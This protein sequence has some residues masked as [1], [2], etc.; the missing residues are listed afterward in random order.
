MRDFKN[1]KW[2][3]FRKKVF[4]RY[5]RKCMKCGT[6]KGPI[7]VDHI[8]AYCKRPD[9]EYDINNTQILCRRCNKQKGWRSSKDYRPLLMRF[10]YWLALT[11]SPAALVFAFLL[12][13]PLLLAAI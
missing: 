13:L 6:T 9:L 2:L 12:F 4:A 1:P 8:I 5:G 3:A 11:A 7:Q 10:R